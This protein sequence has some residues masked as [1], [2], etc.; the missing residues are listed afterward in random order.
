[1][2][3][4]LAPQRTPRFSIVKRWSAVVPG[5]TRPCNSSPSQLPESVRRGSA[6]ALAP[7]DLPSARDESIAASH[8]PPG[9]IRR[10]PSPRA[11]WRLASASPRRSSN[12]EK[13]LEHHFCDYLDHQFVPKYRSSG[14]SR[15]P[16]GCLLDARRLVPVRTKLPCPAD[17]DASVSFES[18][19][20][21]HREAVY[22]PS[23]VS[24]IRKKH[25]A[26]CHL[27]AHLASEGR[28]FQ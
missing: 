6:A 10:Q 19:Q 18:S 22:R 2:I 15:S 28:S 17:G 24:H 21:S 11:C 7:V 3:V 13:S 8:I 16:D 5:F 25:V 4:V 9:A 12:A 27:L 26:S 14:A 20:A 1:M 23:V